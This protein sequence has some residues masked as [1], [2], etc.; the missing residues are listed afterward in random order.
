MSVDEKTDITE[1]LNNI[2]RVNKRAKTVNTKKLSDVHH[3]F[4]DLYTRERVLFRL[5]TC[6]YPRL[7]FKSLYHY[8]EENDPMFNGDFMVG[9][10]TPKGPIAYHFKL[11]Y[12]SD[13]THLSFLPKKKLLQINICESFKH[14]LPQHC[15]YLRPLPHG[16]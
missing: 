16:F 10:Y 2:I 3:T 15:L 8:D 9:M 13:F 7:C 11:A 4:G 12:L 1:P 14:Y 6:I 5:I